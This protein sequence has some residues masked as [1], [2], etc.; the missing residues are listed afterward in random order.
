MSRPS[1]ARGFNLIEVLIGLVV[2][3]VLF[4]AG[5]PTVTAWLQSTQVRTSAEAVI[6]GLQLARTE[7]VRR[8]RSVQFS[9]TDT[10][11]AG[12]A[13]SLT[14]TNWVISLV[15]PTGAC[16]ATPSDTAAPQILQKRNGQEGSPNATVTTTSSVVTFNAL[17]RPTAGGGATIDIKSSQGTCQ[18]AAGQI[19]CLRISVGSSGSAR[20]CDPA[21]TDA[22]DSRCCFDSTNTVCVP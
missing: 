4:A 21:V 13:P 2:L 18:G 15:D 7:A 1:Q 5:L 6:S 16:N 12:C 10:L 20:M 11:S 14:G 8:N 22:T 19:R 3:G 17:G 9:L